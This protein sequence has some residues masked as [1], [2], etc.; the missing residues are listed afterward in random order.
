MKEISFILF[1]SV[2]FMACTSNTIIKKPDNLIPKNQME[3]LITDML[4]AAGAENIKN[5]DLE[6]NLNYF[7]LVFEKYG[8]DSTR[9]KESNYYY[10]S[11][12]DDYEKILKKVNERLK[13][14]KE[15][16]DNEIKLQDSLKNDS[17]KKNRENFKRISEKLRKIDTIK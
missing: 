7:P 10:T 15:K 5:V 8:I 16:L 9:F 3:D 1:L 17:M 2:F 4:I 12:I 14:L 11:Q 13:A 6:R